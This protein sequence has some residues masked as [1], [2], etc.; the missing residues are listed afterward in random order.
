MLSPLDETLRHQ[1]PTTFD[2][3]GTSDPRFFDR[4]WF[5]IYDPEGGEPA[6]NLGMCS[7][8]NMNVVD[9]YAAFIVEGRQHNIRL[10]RLLRPALY[11][12]DPNVT[13]LGP[14]RVEIIEPFRRLRLVL[15]ANDHGLGFDLEWAAVLP[16]HEELP[17]F[18][19]VRGRVNQDYF[20]YNQ[21]GTVNGWIEVNGQRR[22]A[23]QWW[24]GRDHSWGVRTDVAGG[25][26]VTG[27]G[28][29][30]AARGG[31]LWTWITFGAQDMGGHI[32]L[33]ELSDGTAVHHEAL[34]RWAD[35][36]Q[37][38]TDNVRLEFERY[39]GTR[40]FSHATWYLDVQSGP[41]TG[42]WRVDAI[43]ISRSLAMV[44]LGYSMGYSDGRGFGV[45]RGD[46][47]EEYDVYDVSHDEDVILADGSTDR[48]YHRDCA[49]T[50][51]VTAPNGTEFHGAG[52]V[53]ILPT[54]SL[55]ARGIQ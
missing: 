30:R 22:E 31:F 24:G 12:A 43:P 27:P 49:V 11:T 38:A 15:G 28:D 2:H 52:H 45:Y 36:S 51:V 9:G 5:A 26:P 8:L 40:R 34:L 14:L 23:T 54:G 7:Y 47:H 18:S 1:L 46:P 13:E 4:Y 17:N 16:A 48:P 6:L 50:L 37:I 53:A 25:E 39:P 32:Q 35:G 10:S 20:R 44:G 41:S 21:S 3:P 33:H 29:D 42:M 19:R 55:E